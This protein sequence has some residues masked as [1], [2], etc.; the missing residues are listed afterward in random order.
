MSQLHQMT[1]VALSNNT[2]ALYLPPHLYM[3]I[4]VVHLAGVDAQRDKVVIDLELV[5]PGHLRIFFVV[6]VLVSRT[7][8]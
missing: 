5:T 2:L 3:G 6:V 7:N 8:Q 4:R 1:K